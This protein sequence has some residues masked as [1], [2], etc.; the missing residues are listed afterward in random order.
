MRRHGGGEGSVVHVMQ[1]E[2]WDSPVLI[3]HTTNV[4]KTIAGDLIVDLLQPSGAYCEEILGPLGENSQCCQKRFSYFIRGRLETQAKTRLPLILLALLITRLSTFYSSR[5]V[6]N[7]TSS[8]P[9]VFLGL[10]VISITH[11]HTQPFKLNGSVSEPKLFRSHGQ[12]LSFHG[13]RG[14]R[15]N[16]GG[17]GEDID[18][19]GEEGWAGVMSYSPTQLHS[20]L[21]AAITHE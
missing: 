12:F 16:A 10:E 7:D 6:P 21:T 19:E 15:L 1:K 5:P 14:A 9:C 11:I 20:D 2:S 4:K 18:A 3:Q 17:L 13:G 8:L